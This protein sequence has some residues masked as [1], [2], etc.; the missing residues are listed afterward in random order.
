[1]GYGVGISKPFS[2]AIAKG[3]ALVGTAFNTGKG[4]V[5]PEHREF[6]HRMI[7]QYHGAAWRPNE[8]IMK[9][10]DMVEIRFGQGANAG[11]G[12]A[13]LRHCVS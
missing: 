12:H 7:V 6:A 8:D 3:T 4:P 2:F 9:Q 11:N 5:L 13:S 10:A 1:M